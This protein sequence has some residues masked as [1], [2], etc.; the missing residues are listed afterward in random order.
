MG[1]RLGL[2]EDVEA[3]AARHRGAAHQPLAD[4]VHHGLELG[5]GIGRP[6]QFLD[7]GRQGIALRSGGRRGNRARR[8][9]A[10]QEEERQESGKDP[11]EHCS[12]VTP[13]GAYAP[14]RRTSKCSLERFPITPNGVIETRARVTLVVTGTCRPA[15]SSRS[16]CALGW[17]AGV[18]YG[19]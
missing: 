16:A 12:S 11:K 7:V 3:K 17:H 10:R 18:L 5:G 1:I 13:A 2:V 19:T 15:E 6:D 4:P 14:A 8:A 9:T